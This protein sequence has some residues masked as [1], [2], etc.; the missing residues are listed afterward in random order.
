MGQAKGDMKVPAIAKV[1]H[2][3]G[4]RYARRF[5]FDIS[6]ETRLGNGLEQ[7]TLIA[8]ESIDR[9]RLNEGAGCNCAGGRC[10][11]AAGGD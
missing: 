3:V 4:V 6:L 2:R 9:W 11:G 1:F 10:A 7:A 5:F 8:E